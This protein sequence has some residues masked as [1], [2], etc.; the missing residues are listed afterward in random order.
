MNPPPAEARGQEE[1]CD[2]MCEDTAAQ[3]VPDG[4]E[5]KQGF[6]SGGLVLFSNRMLSGCRVCI[7]FV[8]FCV[9]ATENPEGGSAGGGV[10]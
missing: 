9:V 7:T 4:Q 10:G 3:M 2:S 1:L 8:F 5:L 6:L